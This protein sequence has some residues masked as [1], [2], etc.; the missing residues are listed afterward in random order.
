MRPICHDGASNTRI[1]GSRDASDS[2]GRCGS[3]ADGEGHRL[4]RAGNGLLDPGTT[5]ALDGDDHRHCGN[6]VASPSTDRNRMSQRACATTMMELCKSSMW[7][8]D[9]SLAGWWASYQMRGVRVL[10]DGARFLA[11]RG[12]SPRAP[13]WFADALPRNVVLDGVIVGMDQ[14]SGSRTQRRREPVTSRAVRWLNAD[15][16]AWRDVRFI[17]T[18]SPTMNCHFA[19]RIMR[20]R[21][22][23]PFDGREE[24]I[25]DLL[26]S[27]VIS[28]RD[29]EWRGSL[30]FFLECAEKYGYDGLVLREPSSEYAD[31]TIMVPTGD[32][33][34]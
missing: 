31:G 20:L 1:G 27:Y 10:W 23:F 13:S 22:M 29:E 9:V 32:R 34:A 28:W 11:Q 24:R 19:M 4:H 5:V 16:A 17:V 7:D 6:R 25:V 15:I 18:D 30:R 3:D 2:Y 8:G 33:Q 21:E 12:A 14:L 26:D